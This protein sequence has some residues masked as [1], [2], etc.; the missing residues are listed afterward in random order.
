MK[1]KLLTALYITYL[2]LI[3]LPLFVVATIVLG[4]IMFVGSLLGGERIFAYYPG[5]LWSRIV[6]WLTF[7]SVELRGKEVYKDSPGPYIVMANHQGAYDIFAMYG[8]LGIPF[9]WVMKE[10]LRRTPVVGIACKA[11][12]FVFVNHLNPVSVKVAL[13][14]IEEI[15]SEGISI[16]IFPEGSR[17]RTGKMMKFKRGGFLMAQ[18]LN[19]PI[20][21][22][23]I[24][25]SYQILPKGRW[26]PKPGKI[27]LQVHSP[28]AP[29]LFAQTEKPLQQLQQ[30]VFDEIAR[31]VQS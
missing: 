21:P 19:V 25:G 11:A 28:V 10:Q 3:A 20:I 13:R 24:S 15:L 5:I 14:K 29:D 27:V 7:C 9:R 17:T 16:F 6:L 12:G 23:S 18:E 1:R 26:C 30:Y 22:V 31:D 2:A 4:T 8:F